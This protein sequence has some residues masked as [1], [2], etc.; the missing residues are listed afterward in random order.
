MSAFVK[1]L[2]ER[3][4]VD[5]INETDNM[6]LYL[7]T[8]TIPRFLWP[9]QGAQTRGPIPSHRTPMVPSPTW[10]RRVADIPVALACKNAYGFK[11]DVDLYSQL[12]NCQKDKTNVLFSP[13]VTALLSAFWWIRALVAFSRTPRWIRVKQGSESNHQYLSNPMSCDVRFYS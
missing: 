1:T 5:A 11:N 4:Q 6:P 8:T 7:T 13:D 12:I 9:P 3:R 2:Q 10:A